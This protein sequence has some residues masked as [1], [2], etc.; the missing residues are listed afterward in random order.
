MIKKY[1][2]LIVILSIAASSPL[3]GGLRWGLARPPPDLPLKGGG[4]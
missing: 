3:R 1:K 2:I 4:N